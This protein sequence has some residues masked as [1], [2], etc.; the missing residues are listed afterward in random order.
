MKDFEDWMGQDVPEPRVYQLK[1]DTCKE[2]FETL[3]YAEIVDYQCPF[4]GEGTM[5]EV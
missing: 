5:E 3:S 2:Q 4:C 1:C